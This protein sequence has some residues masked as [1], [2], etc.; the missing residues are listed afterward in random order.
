MSSFYPNPHAPSCPWYQAA[1]T[2]GAPNL[3]WCEE[4]LCTW[5][6]EP[7]NAWSNIAY[8]LVALYFIYRYRN[9]NSRILK[10]LPVMN[11][12]MGLF[13]FAYHASNFYISQIFDF[14]G[15]YLE[16]L[17]LIAIN[18]TRLGWIVEKN[19]IK[20]TLS[21]TLILTLFLHLLYL[22]DLNFQFLILVLAL[23]MIGSEI[24]LMRTP[25]RAPKMK[26]FFAG[27]GLSVFAISFSII[28]HKRIYCDPTNHFIQGHALWHIAAAIMFI[29]LFKH[30]EQIF[31]EKGIA[32]PD[33]SS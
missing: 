18:F 7:A 19:L 28:D 24:I 32:P 14:V 2:F 8:I 5:I 11:L 31:N 12:L 30:Y 26:H 13:S 17:L 20:F 4:T 6:S 10:A 9:H 22:N 23:L 27:V 16:I 3:K 1:E 21:G 33:S 25:L 15:M 29:F